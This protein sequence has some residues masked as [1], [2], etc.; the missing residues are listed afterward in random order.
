MD[1]AERAEQGF[2]YTQR[3]ILKIDVAAIQSSSYDEHT[4]FHFLAEPRMNHTCL[5]KRA[6]LS[7]LAV[8]TLS[9]LSTW[10]GTGAL[11]QEAFP[12]RAITIVVPFPPGGSTDVV[13]R[14]LAKG[15]SDQLGQPVIVE[16]RQGAGTAVGAGYVAKA[17]PDGYTLLLSSGST[18]TANPALRSNLPYDS[19]KSF[20]P[21]GVVGR[22]PL[23]LLANNNAPANNVREFVAAVKRTPDQL[24]YASYGSGTTAHFTGEM[25]MHSIGGKIMH[26]PYRGSAPAMTDLIGGQVPFS[27]DTVTAALPQ[28]KAGKVKA[29]AVTTAKRSSLLA[30]VPTFAEA[31]YKDINAETWFM[32]VLPKGTPETARTTLENAVAKV[33]STPAIKQSL[34]EQGMEVAFENRK[35]ASALIEKELPLMRATAARANIKAD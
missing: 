26:V 27:V 23:I 16:N 32:L 17:K 2:Q 30:N 4:F 9:V 7:T 13:G 1:E 18:F 20:D 25:V 29:I 22:I 8:A 24:A 6:T 31:G 14:L 34:Q 19:I 10:T 33:V 35:A 3:K 5:L 28:L 15:I 12:S 11:A 21:V